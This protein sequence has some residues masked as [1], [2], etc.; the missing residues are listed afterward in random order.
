MNDLPIVVAWVI[1]GVNA[2]AVALM[3]HRLR[4]LPAPGIPTWRRRAILWLVAG[5]IIGP[6]IF[7]I[8][9]TLAH[10]VFA[11][12]E[13]SANT[14]DLFGDAVGAIMM[15]SIFDI[16]IALLFVA[17]GYLPVL[18]FWARI[19]RDSAGSRAHFAA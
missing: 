18:L 13:V 19:V 11:W 10:V 9:A 6:V 2:V 3:W 7:V 14:S 17:P 1:A 15:L 8:L 12:R 16:A 4:H 5:A